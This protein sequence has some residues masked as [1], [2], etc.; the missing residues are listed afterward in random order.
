LRRET[1]ET[2]KTNSESISSFTEKDTQLDNNFKKYITDLVLFCKR[3]TYHKQFKIDI[4]WSETLDEIND[5]AAAAIYSKP[6]YFIA[7]IVI[8]PH[9]FEYY[10][11]KDYA[12]VGN[13]ILHEICHLYY[14][15]ITDMF[16][17][18]M[19]DHFRQLFRPTLERQVQTTRDT[20]AS[21]LPIDWY[22]P[23]T[24]AALTSKG[25]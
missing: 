4:E 24:V 14:T 3:E 5:E 20:I 23:K 7:T 1:R 9:I 2:F 22:M 8:Y 16:E 13:I 15:P 25:K 18:F 6:E 19:S 17:Q 11:N 21:L 10:K 12:T